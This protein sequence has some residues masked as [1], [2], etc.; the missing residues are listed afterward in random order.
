MGLGLLGEPELGELGLLGGL[1]IEGV[2]GG[3]CSADWQTGQHEQSNPCYGSINSS[4][5]LIHGPI[6]NTRQARTIGVWM[7]DRPPLQVNA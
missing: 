6:L 1:G 5:R 3:D 7:V 2:E 4:N